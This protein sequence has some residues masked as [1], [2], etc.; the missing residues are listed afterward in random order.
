MIADDIKE[1]SVPPRNGGFQ[2]NFFGEPVEYV[3]EGGR[4][5]RLGWWCEGEFDPYVISW[6]DQK[7]GE[8]AQT[9]QNTAG[10][11]FLD[12]YAP[13]QVSEI[14]NHEGGIVINL[15]DGRGIK[16]IYVGAPFFYDFKIA[17]KK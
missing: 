12:H 15:V 9:V 14:F 4:V 13:F 5:W 10:C 1:R 16:A 7:T 17:V 8:W 3:D 11:F 2:P 6:N